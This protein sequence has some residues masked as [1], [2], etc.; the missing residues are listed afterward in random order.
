[1]SDEYV[2]D[3]KMRASLTDNGKVRLVIYKREGFDV[4]CCVE[5]YETDSPI[6]KGIWRSLK[7]FGYPPFERYGKYYAYG[8]YISFVRELIKSISYGRV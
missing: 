6:G 2:P 4:W 1:M 5:I 3:Y 7:K 8:W